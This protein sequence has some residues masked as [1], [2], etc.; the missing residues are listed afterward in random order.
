MRD[1]RA[2]IREGHYLLFNPL[3]AKLLADVET[4]AGHAELALNLVNETVSEAEQTGQSWFDA[5]LYRAR[6]ELLLQCGRPE[7][8]ASE[9]AFKHAIDVTR[10]QQTRAFELRSALSLAKLYQSS[11]RAADARAVLA[12]A[13]EGFSPTQE[14]PEIEQAQALLGALT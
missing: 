3:Y 11:G 9:A 14:F 1:L 4:G 13:L 10:R 7:T 2:Q 8:T 12:P 6:G 5:E